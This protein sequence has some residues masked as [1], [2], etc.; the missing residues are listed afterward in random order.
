MHACAASVWLA[1]ALLP[2]SLWVSRSLSNGQPIQLIWTSALQNNNNYYENC[3]N[4][5]RKPKKKNSVREKERE[6][7][8][9][10]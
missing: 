4:K 10:E 2:R 3:N 5:M 6:S 8:K 9:Q 1:F 7:E